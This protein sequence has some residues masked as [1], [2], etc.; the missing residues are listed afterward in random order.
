MPEPPDDQIA[1][2]VMT[3]AAGVRAFCPSCA[4]HRAVWV[5]ETRGG[6]TLTGCGTCQRVIRRQRT[7]D[8]PPVHVNAHASCR[9]S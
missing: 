2:Y 1:T 8:I 4:T 5:G 7:A 3:A 9:N 6:D